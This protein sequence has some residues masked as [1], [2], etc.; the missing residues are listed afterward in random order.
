M[1]TA[2]AFSEECKFELVRVYFYFIFKFS[3]LGVRF[4]PVQAC[5]YNA[6]NPYRCK[7]APGQ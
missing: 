3:V 7:G 1:L 2:R 6:A 5:R 4:C